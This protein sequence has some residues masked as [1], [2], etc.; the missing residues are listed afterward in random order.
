[1]TISDIRPLALKFHMAH[2]TA[3]RSQALQ[4]ERNTTVQCL[5]PSLSKDCWKGGYSEQQ[6]KNCPR[7]ADFLT[8]PS[9]RLRPLPSFWP[10]L[11]GKAATFLSSHVAQEKGVPGAHPTLRV[12]QVASFPN[13]IT[14][15]LIKNTAFKLSFLV[16]QYLFVFPRRTRCR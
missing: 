14:C 12:D 16:F 6:N 11:R 7:I 1:M 10:R 2:G 9:G 13:S 8:T 3:C 5:C 15:A 4:L